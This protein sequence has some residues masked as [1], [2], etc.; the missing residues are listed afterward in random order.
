M[1]R[2]YKVGGIAI[3]DIKLYYK[4]A[5]IRQ[6]DIGIR[7]DIDKWNRLENP[8]INSNLYGQLIFDKVGMNTQLS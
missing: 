3:P 6:S 8:E 2:K 7:M 5:V 1:R 4:V